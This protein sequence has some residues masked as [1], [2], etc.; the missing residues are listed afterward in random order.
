MGRWI[1][2]AEDRVERWAGVEMIWEDF[3]FVL[4]P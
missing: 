1:E 4:K 3:T 2:L